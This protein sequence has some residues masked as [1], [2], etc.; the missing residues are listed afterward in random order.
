MSYVPGFKFDVFI[1]YAHDSN[2]PASAGRDRGWVSELWEDLNKRLVGE[3]APSPTIFMDDSNLRKAGAYP[4]DLEKALRRSALL[5]TINCEPY[6]YA[7]WCVWELEKFRDEF[8]QDPRTKDGG[9]RIVEVYK[10][11]LPG[12]QAPK[13]QKDNNGIWFC[14]QPRKGGDVLVDQPART[15]ERGSEDYEKALRVLIDE[16][17]RLLLS[18][19][20]TSKSIFISRPIDYAID[21]GSSLTKL[22][23]DLRNDLQRKYQVVPAPA[24]VASDSD[25]AQ[26]TVSVHFLSQT[27]DESTYKNI[28]SAR[29]A[30]KRLF[31]VV[32]SALQPNSIV[33]NYLKTLEESID[34]TIAESESASLR[35]F[36]FNPAKHAVSDVVS[37]ILGLIPVGGSV[38]PRDLTL[39]LIF[40]SKDMGEEEVDKLLRIIDKLGSFDAAGTLSLS[41]AVVARIY[42]LFTDARESNRILK[43]EEIRG[44]FRT[45]DLNLNPQDLA[46]ASKAF[47]TLQDIS[48]VLESGSSHESPVSP[49]TEQQFNTLWRVLE[50]LSLLGVKLEPLRSAQGKQDAFRSH[51]QYLNACDGLL[52]L[53]GYAHQTWFQNYLGQVENAPGFRKGGRP[54]DSRVILVKPRDA[55]K[56]TLAKSL[57][58]TDYVWEGVDLSKLAVFLMALTNRRKNVNVPTY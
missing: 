34:A 39:Y 26:S 36:K 24:V 52:L 44:L 6:V 17:K 37:E 33:A 10:S 57:L 55:K 48:D 22:Y 31:I 54:L 51:M 2:Q 40:D 38:R 45:G 41:E 23:K 20:S 11:L 53:W 18:M 7:D 4:E 58:P 5:L 50:A 3:M 16:I 1:S 47:R 46:G 15:F 30:G 42:S 13:I 14:S 43:D 12:G 29:E 32:S 27:Y 56:A 9:R 8:D 49:I 19:R 35:V 25:L 28:E 21:P